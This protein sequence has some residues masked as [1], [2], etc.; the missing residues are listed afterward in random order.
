VRVLSRRFRWL[1]LEGL[2]HLYDHGELALT[3]RCRELAEG[4]PWKRLLAALRDKEWAV[5]AKEPIPQPQRVLTY[6]A[7][8]THRVAIS[9]HRLVALQDGQVTFRFKDYKRGGKLRT[10][11]MDAVEFL[12]R[13]TL[14]ILPKGLHKIRYFGLLANRHR[15]AKLTR[16]RL[17][18]GQYTDAFDDAIA[19]GKNV[20]TPE[21]EDTRLEPGDLCP[22]CH[23]GYMKLVETYNR[24][25]AA[26]NL[27]IPPPELDTS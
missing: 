17:L 12:R 4:K 19:A 22:V 5:Y 3:G 16:C 23:Q 11:T 2:E 21:T 26:W 6:L 27:L 7:R 18:L 1:Y 13:F 14:H 10:Q 25:E 20:P 24:H 8:Y 9:N 15:E